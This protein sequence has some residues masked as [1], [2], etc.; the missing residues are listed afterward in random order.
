ME[1]KLTDKERKLVEDNLEIVK[2]IIFKNFR[3]DNNKIDFNF[4]ELYQVGC[5]ALCECVRK[6]DNSTKFTTFASIVV[7]SKL[8][9][10]CKKNNAINNKTIFVDSFEIQEVVDFNARLYENDVFDILKN[11]KPKS[12]GVALK[13][14][15]ALEL[16]IKGFNGKEIA[17]MYGTSTNNVSAWISRAKKQLMSNIEFINRTS[18]LHTNN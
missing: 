6:Y 11:V 10:Y 1:E 8:L 9:T 5:L 13:G 3:Y 14:I 2:I 18:Y 7:R 12:K 16:K 4:E 15:I 17:D